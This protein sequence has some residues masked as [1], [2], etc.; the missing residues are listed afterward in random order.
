MEK[1]I[2][3]DARG[4]S[5]PQPAYLTQKAIN[6]L[7]SGTIEVLVDTPTSCENIIFLAKRAGWEV[8]IKES[9]EDY[10]KLE[11]KK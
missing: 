11:L 2:N 8:L 1:F 4:L 5:C 7:T 6:Q 3:I 10:Y 9:G